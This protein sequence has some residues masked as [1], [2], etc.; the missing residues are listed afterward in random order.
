MGVASVIRK[1]GEGNSQKWR[2]KYAKMA[3]VIR[4]NDEGNSHVSVIYIHE[5]LYIRSF[6]V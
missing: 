1:N 4:K 3:R 5:D 2:G 6:G